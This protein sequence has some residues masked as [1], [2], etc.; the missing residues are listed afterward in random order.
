MFKE[1]SRQIKTAASGSEITVSVVPIF[2]AFIF[3]DR[4]QLLRDIMAI[5]TTKVSIPH[6]EEEGIN[7][8][9]VLEQWEPNADTKGRRIA[10]ASLPPKYIFIDCS[11]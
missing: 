10:L 7:I 11:R 4:C 2:I 9:G 3:L 8:A 5:Q 6:T 1:D